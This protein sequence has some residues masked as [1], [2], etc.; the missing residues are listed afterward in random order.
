MAPHSTTSVG[1]LKGNLC[2]AI[3][4]DENCPVVAKKADLRTLNIS[5]NHRRKPVTYQVSISI[6]YRYVSE[7]SD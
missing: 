1:R 5:S 7:P 6:A 3:L 2:E 4:D